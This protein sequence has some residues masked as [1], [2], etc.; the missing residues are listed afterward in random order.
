MIYSVTKIAGLTLPQ[1]AILTC[2]SWIEEGK[3][4]A[5]RASGHRHASQVSLRT[6]WAVLRY[7]AMVIGQVSVYAV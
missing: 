2:K 6:L 5:K 4:L 1:I 3:A 7:R